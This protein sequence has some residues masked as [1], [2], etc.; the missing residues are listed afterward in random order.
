MFGNIGKMI[1]MAA[2]MKTKLPEMKERLAKSTYT[3]S[4][5]GSAVS[6]TVDGKM[7]IVE[8]KIDQAVL[9][10]ENMDVDM[11]A[12]L[13]KAAVSSAQAEA[14]KAAADAMSELTG[15]MDIPGM[16]NLLG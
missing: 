8:L 15:G 7:M 16:D 11:L 6:V 14:A 9:S 10:D 5:G 2:E 3:A 1:Q 13:I 4:A 12:D